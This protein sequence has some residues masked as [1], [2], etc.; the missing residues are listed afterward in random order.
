MDK[1]LEEYLAKMEK[2]LKPLPFVE[3]QD[4]IKEL[5]S[6][7]QDLLR[8]QT[9]IEQI[10]ER[11]GNPKE[12]AK[13]YLGEK[14]ERTGRFSWR[15]VLVVCGFYSL[16]GFSGMVVI[17]TLAIV[18]PLFMLCGIIVP[19]AALV[20][21]LGHLFHFYFPLL[22]HIGINIP[23]LVMNPWVDFLLNVIVSIAIT[24]AGYWSW[25]LLVLY[26]KKVSQTAKSINPKRASS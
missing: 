1:R 24:Y 22:Q 13:S 11:L 7:I 5:H 3:R 19:L 9:P 8:E 21:L 6:E 18:A 20:K 25:K 16:V 14:L 15:Q 2:Y 4:I 10:L 23:G 12:L 26:C 17:P